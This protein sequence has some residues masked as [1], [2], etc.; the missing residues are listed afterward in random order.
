MTKEL[1]IVCDETIESY[2]IYNTPGRLIDRGRRKRVNV[3]EL[4]PG[5]YLIVLNGEFRERFVKY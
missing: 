5:F 1:Q 2:E 4:L 3:S